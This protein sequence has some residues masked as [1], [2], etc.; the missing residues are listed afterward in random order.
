MERERN[1]LK[2][3]VSQWESEEERRALKGLKEREKRADAEICKKVRVEERERVQRE[4]TR[5]RK[6]AT[7]ISDGL[8][9][10]SVFLTG[11]V[12]MTLQLTQQFNIRISM[13]SCIVHYSHYCYKIILTSQ[14]WTVL[15]KHCRQSSVFFF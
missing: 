5:G 11:I 1:Q 10:Y 14:K 3:K 2:R 4:F 12:I 15:E 13:S 6:K 8:A 9:T 7:I